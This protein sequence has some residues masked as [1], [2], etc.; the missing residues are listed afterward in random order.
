MPNP[1]AGII[2]Q[3]FKDLHTNMIS[4]L[5]EDTALTTKCSL[6]YENTR[7]EV[8]NNC[9]YSALG[10]RSSR[11]YKIGGPNPFNNGVCPVCGGQGKIYFSST[12]SLYLMTIFNKR[13]WI[14]TNPNAVDINLQ[15]MSLIST[16]DD[17]QRCS[18]LTID[19][20]K[21]AKYNGV[22]FIRDGSPVPCGF[23]DNNFIIT[24]W[25]LS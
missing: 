25:K 17:I 21:Y 5:L 1:F 14:I 13:D 20:S 3:D 24:S 23:D 7:F 6:I 18:F 19:D 9:I 22:R 8:C 11:I 12:T 4:A 10:G 16:F 15:T 2:T